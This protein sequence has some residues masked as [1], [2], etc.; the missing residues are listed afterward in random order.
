[1][2]ESYFGKVPR[3]INREILYRVKPEDL[4]LVCKFDTYLNNICEKQEF[5][6][7]YSQYWT[8][9]IVKKYKDNIINGLDLVTKL[10]YFPLIIDFIKYNQIINLSLILYFLLKNNQWDFLEQ[11]IRDSRDMD[12]LQRK[13]SLLTDLPG[14]SDGYDIHYRIFTDLFRACVKFNYSEPKRFEFVTNSELLKIL[15]KE[16][17]MQNSKY[18]NGKHQSGIAVTLLNSGLMTAVLNKHPSIKIIEMLLSEIIKTLNK[19]NQQNIIN[20]VLNLIE[21]NPHLIIS[22]E[23]INLL[24][25]YLKIN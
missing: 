23:I 16:I 22:P 21:R 5:L 4:L 14:V 24:K 1:M 11:L 3:D 12:A 10:G 9:Y 19:E 2:D 15:L 8:E 6:D 25:T 20:N 17:Y 7:S 13:M 18:F